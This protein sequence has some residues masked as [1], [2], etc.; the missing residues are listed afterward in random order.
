MPAQIT[1]P[2][3]L[4]PG[5]PHTQPQWLDPQP[6]YQSA[7]PSARRTAAAAGRGEVPTGEEAGKQKSVLEAP[8]TVVKRKLT[9]SSPVTEICADSTQTLVLQGA[10]RGFLL[11]IKQ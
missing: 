11:G 7:W 9:I 2:H 6:G 5:R 10:G 8:K 4:P 1:G 3:I